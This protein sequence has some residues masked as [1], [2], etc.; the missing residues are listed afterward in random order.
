MA[1]DLRYWVERALEGGL[2]G[3]VNDI[4]N[5]STGVKLDTPLKDVEAVLESLEDDG[6]AFVSSGCWRHTSAAKNLAHEGDT[7]GT[8]MRSL[9]LIPTIDPE[10][11]L[12]LSFKDGA[13]SFRL[14]RYIVGSRPEIVP[15]PD[16]GNNVD[17]LRRLHPFSEEIVWPE[18]DKKSVD[19]AEFWAGE[20]A[21]RNH[22]RA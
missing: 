11:Y 22:G 6:I 15:V 12:H 9:V 5:G 3:T 14:R 18:E 4:R 21:K 19:D 10:N 8:Q 13:R 2:V 16:A 7:P 1:R 17:Q 20:I